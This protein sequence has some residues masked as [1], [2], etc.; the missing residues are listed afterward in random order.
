[1]QSNTIITVR[2]EVAKVMFSQACVCPRGGG[3][4]A[5]GGCLVWGGVWSRG[6][7][8]LRGSGG[9]LVSQHAMRQTPPPPGETA[10]AADG[11]HPTGMH[12]CLVIC[13]RTKLVSF[14][15]GSHNCV[16]Y[17]PVCSAI[18]YAFILYYKTSILAIH[19]LW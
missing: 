1:M 11:T 15:Y 17:F 8:L 4:S 16:I 6:C 14:T 2:N 7:L 9:E 13:C 12:S 10:T 18:R 3:V 5:P 19:A